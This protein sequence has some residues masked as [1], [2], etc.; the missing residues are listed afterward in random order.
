MTDATEQEWHIVALQ[1]PASASKAA[2]AA[3][4]AATPAPAP[5]PAPAVPKVDCD[6]T[7]STVYGPSAPPQVVSK[8]DYLFKNLPPHL[9]CAWLLNFGLRHSTPLTLIHD[10]QATNSA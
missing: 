2:T 4:P 7:T 6:E 8:R 5:A 3:T 10:H 1:Q 9:R